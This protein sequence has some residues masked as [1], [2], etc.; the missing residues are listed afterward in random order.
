MLL[1]FLAFSLESRFHYCAISLASE[2]VESFIGISSNYHSSFISFS[3]LRMLP[4]TFHSIHASS[5]LRSM[6]YSSIFHS[7]LRRFLS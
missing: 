3:V 4:R 2:D 6:L 1:L 7:S 5:P